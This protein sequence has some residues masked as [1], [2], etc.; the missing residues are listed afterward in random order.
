MDNKGGSSAAI[1]GGSGENTG[2]LNAPENLTGAVENF[3]AAFNSEP[4]APDETGEQ[5]EAA[6]DDAP[7]M[8]SPEE[9]AEVAELAAKPQEEPSL[10]EQE[11][12]EFGQILETHSKRNEDDIDKRV[13]AEFSRDMK[14]YENDPATLASVVAGESWKYMEAVFG[15]RRGDGLN[16]TGAAAA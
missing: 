5:A 16:G 9:R 7:E 13:A 6:V 8:G 10:V 2:F 3:E 14:K 11:V 15:R 4:M 1:S 12:Q